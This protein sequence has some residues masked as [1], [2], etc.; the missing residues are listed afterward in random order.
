[1]EHIKLI[2]PSSKYEEQVMRAREDILN[3]GEH[4]D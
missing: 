3:L 2:V 1:M 4:F